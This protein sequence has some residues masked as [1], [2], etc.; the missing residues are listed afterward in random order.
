MAQL[1]KL[2]SQVM[3]NFAKEM[4]TIAELMRK[5]GKMGSQSLHTGKYITHNLNTMA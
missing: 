5:I 2:L 1:D 4:E 3:D